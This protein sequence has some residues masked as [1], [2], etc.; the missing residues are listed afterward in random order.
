M[1]SLFNVGV[2]YTQQRE[3]DRLK[4]VTEPFLV[5]AETF[6]NAEEIMYKE[7][8]KLT[9]GEFFIKSI[10][11]E[12]YNTILLNEEDEGTYYNAIVSYKVD[13]DSSSKKVN[14]KFLIETSNIDNVHEIIKKHF[15]D[16]ISEFSLTRVALSNILYIVQEKK[17]V[18]IEEIDSEY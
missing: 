16:T 4:R 9:R 12:N 6:G 11:R 1:S 17:S 8:E 13:D 10:K 7:M 18:Q 14:I 15:S 3:D 2:R 5:V